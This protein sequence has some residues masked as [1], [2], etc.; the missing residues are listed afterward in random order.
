[1]SKGYR[2]AREAAAA[3]GFAQLALGL[4]DE[5]LGETVEFADVDVD[6][7]D[8]KLERLLEAV[9]AATAKPKPCRCDH[10]LLDRD[11]WDG[12][13]HCIRCGRE[14]PA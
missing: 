11:E 8:R 3:A 1:V 12:A 14:A 10:P 13:M 7:G 4:R 5:E 6:A 9:R 2:T